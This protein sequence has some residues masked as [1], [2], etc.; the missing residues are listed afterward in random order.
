MRHRVAAAETAEQSLVESSV[1]TGWMA[2]VGWAVVV[3]GGCTP[4]EPGD[5]GPVWPDGCSDFRCLPPGTVDDGHDEGEPDDAE[6]EDD[7]DTDTGADMEQ[8]FDVGP[9]DTGT[10]DHG[11]AKVDFLFI[12][13]TTGSMEDEQ[14]VLVEAFPG[15]IDAIV[16]ALGHQSD[17]HIMVIDTDAW[18]RCNTANPWEGVDPGSEYCTE[19]PTNTVF[20]ECDRVRGAGVVHPIGQY[21]SDE[22]CPVQGGHRYI[23]AG[24]PDLVGTF[25][26]IASVGIAGHHHERPM[27]GLVAAMSPELNG[28]G[29]C[30]EGFIRDDALLVIT[31][32]SDDTFYHDTG[33]PQQWYESVLDAK[34]GDPNAAVMLGLTPDWDGCNPGNG[35]TQG[36]HWTELIE[37]FGD[38]GLVG[39]ICGSA[40]EYVDFFAQA[41]AT[42]DDACDAYEPPG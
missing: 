16:D 41:V 14:A 6:G 17:H 29:G 19:Y 12:I 21:A 9:P 11:C 15:F 34:L 22:L 2:V 35:R 26:C 39:N 37:M 4:G 8:K 5:E 36:A 38:N 1:K 23:T 13:D 24:Q 10:V 25:E 3:G 18:G 31:M 42:I 32:L 7:L 27:D 30:N 33:T 20:E 28:P 40:Q